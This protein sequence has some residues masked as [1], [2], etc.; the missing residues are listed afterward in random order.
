M[1]PANFLFPELVKNYCNARFL[2]LTKVITDNIA[3]FY[4]PCSHLQVSNHLSLLTESLPSDS[5]EQSSTAAIS[6]GNRNKC[7]VPGTL[8]NSNTL[9]SFYAIDKQSLLKQ[10]AKKVNHS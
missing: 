9:E 1:N 5:N 6:R 2:K 10:E 4:A 8:Y 7:T 3:G